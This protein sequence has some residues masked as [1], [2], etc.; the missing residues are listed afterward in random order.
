VHLPRPILASAFQK[1][2]FIQASFLALTV[3]LS[4]TG[5]PAFAHRFIDFVKNFADSVMRGS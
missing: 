4:A 3:F 5:N 2:Q 1:P